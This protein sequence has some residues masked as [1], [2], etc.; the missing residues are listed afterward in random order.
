M[1]SLSVR[2]WPYR[3]GSQG[4]RNLQAALQ[5]EGVDCLRVRTNGGYRPKVNHLTINWGNSQVPRWQ[6]LVDYEL[7]NHV[8]AVQIASN[9]LLT[10]RRFGEVFGATE[11]RPYPWWTENKIVAESMITQYD[12]KVYCR[13]KLTG[14]GGEGIVVARTIE[15]LVDAPLYTVGIDVKKEYR[16][17][18]FDNKVIDITQK[19]RRIDADGNPR[20]CNMDIRNLANDW[21][22]CHGN[23]NPPESVMEQS[24]KAIQA[25]GLDFGAVDVVIDREG[26]AYVLEINTA[27][28]L[29][30]PQTIQA[31]VTAIKEKLNVS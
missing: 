2:L 20:N 24:L 3:F 30:S 31:Y 29:D 12:K 8:P 9:K 23:V 22:F 26:T 25:L 28:G 18:I 1:P 7:L 4:A 13:T 11:V 15:E 21:V 16:V 5:A 19:R 10:F 14:K 27:P 17:H 6:S